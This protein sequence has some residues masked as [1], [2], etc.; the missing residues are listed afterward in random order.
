VQTQQAYRDSLLGM[1]N[2]QVVP[3]QRQYPSGKAV[4]ASPLLLRAIW[5]DANRQVL[6]GNDY[7]EDALLSHLVECFG[8]MRVMYGLDSETLLDMAD[9]TVPPEGE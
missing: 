7:E 2:D 1:G 4:V 6:V 3:P 9:T 5:A 8:V